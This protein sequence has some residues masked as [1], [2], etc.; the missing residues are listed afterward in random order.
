MR[1]NREKVERRQEARR[2]L[3]EQPAGRLAQTTRPRGN[4]VVDERDLQRSLERMEA[5]VGR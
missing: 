5:V 3:R 2:R 4:S 1:P